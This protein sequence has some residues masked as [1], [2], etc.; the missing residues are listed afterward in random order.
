MGYN[1]PSIMAQV[2]VYSKPGCHL[3][4][5][6]VRL[7]Q[8][9]QKQHPFTLEEVNIQDDPALLAEYGEQQVSV[10][11]RRGRGPPAP[12]IEGGELTMRIRAKELRRTQKRSEERHKARHKDDPKNAA[13]TA[14]ATPK[15]K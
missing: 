14:A 2:T 6:A 12:A 9:V 1:G 13:I 3:C 4:E 7:L 15:R 5:E 10:R 8:R 11:V